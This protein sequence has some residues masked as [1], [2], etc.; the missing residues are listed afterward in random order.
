MIY[1]RQ[2][3]KMITYN[4]RLSAFF[5][6]IFT[7]SFINVESSFA[8][9][10]KA[11]FTT[12]CASCHHP[13]KESTGPA[14]AGAMDRVPSKEWMYDWVK[15]SAKVISSG[16]KYA[17]DIY[18]KYNKVAMTAFPNL[19]NEEI[20]AIFAYVE[21]AATTNSGDSGPK[22]EIPQP[23]Q[24]NTWIYV[25]VTLVLVA[26]VAVLWRVNSTLDKT[27]NE[28]AGR[29]NKK[30][31]PFLKNK[32]V[33]T[34]IAVVLL[35][36]AGYWVAN[37]S[38]EMHRQQNYMPSQPIFYSHKVHA[39]IN[40]INCQYCH[41]GAE[42]SRHALIPSTNTCMNCHMQISEYTG[43]QLYDYE[44]NKID[45]T[46][47]IQKLYEYAG[48]DKENGKYR[49]KEDGSIDA[50]PIPWTKIHNLPD[51]V[52]F[53][54]AQHVG[55]GKVQCQSCH[56]EIQYMDE[57]KQFAP[58]SMGW[59]INCHRETEVQFTNNDYYQ[60]FTKY[61]EDVKSGKKSGVTVEDVGGID[62]QKCHY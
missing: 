28:K 15:N 25:L 14:L 40:Q 36:M 39:G 8:Q 26:L 7:F 16:D 43:E 41:V 54:H 1:K 55:V 23:E 24:S 17:N 35:S 21:S 20:D 53:S 44:G 59:C 31:V 46:A 42:D 52:Y 58:L 37:G 51:H 32:V 4:W 6:L 19:T 10:G 3:G 61:H 50:K 5:A 22:I 49:L 45:G 57:V 33:V 29:P 47:E 56:G 12:N 48:W 11:L 9:D 60:I 13:V 18:N 62:C 38:I 34:C 27:A 30:D 2:I